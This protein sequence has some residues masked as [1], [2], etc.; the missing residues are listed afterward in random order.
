MNNPICPSKQKPICEICG[1]EVHP[2]HL[3]CK[4]HWKIR[5]EEQ[6]KGMNY[7]IKKTN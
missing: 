7:V 6:F 1:I 2:G 5:S 4:E 3:L